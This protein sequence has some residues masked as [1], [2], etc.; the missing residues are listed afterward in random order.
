MRYP[1]GIVK[2]NIIIRVFPKA[3]Q[4]ST[5]VNQTPSTTYIIYIS[6]M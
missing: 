2:L 5:L 6:Y 4:N 3:R 1:V